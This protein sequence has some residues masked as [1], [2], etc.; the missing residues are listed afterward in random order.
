[1]TKIMRMIVL[2]LAA[3]I[4]LSETAWAIDLPEGPPPD[5]GSCM[6]APSMHQ[7]PPPAPGLMLLMNHIH[8]NVLAQLTGLTQENVR[9]MLVCAPPQAI[10]DQYDVDPKDFFAAMDKQIGKLVS[11]AAAGNVIS[12]KQAEDIQKRMTAK[13]TMHKGE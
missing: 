7:P 12:K 11:E 10:L 4:F 3:G 13:R 6:A 2:I 5:Q 9:M 1:M 8:V